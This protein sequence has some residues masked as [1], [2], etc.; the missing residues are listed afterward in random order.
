VPL[1]ITTEL[2]EAR[3]RTGRPNAGGPIATAGS[4]VFVGASDDRK[5]RAFD[6]R[7]G[8]ELW[9]AQLPLPGQ[10]VP[11]TYLARNGKQYVAIVAGGSAV[12]D[13]ATAA[14]RPALIAYSLP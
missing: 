5:F 7:T 2:A 6:S 9:A 13:S 1:G 3:Q 4:L 8:E 14:G 10:A 12:A 11:I